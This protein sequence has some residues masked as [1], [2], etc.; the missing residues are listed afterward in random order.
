MLRKLTTYALSR[1]LANSRPGYR[2]KPVR[3]YFHLSPSGDFLGLQ[4]VPQTSEAGGHDGKILCPDIGMTAETR[5]CSVPIETASV[6]L[7]LIKKDE[8]C[9]RFY[10]Q[11]LEEGQ[12]IEPMLG[13]CLKAL[14]NKEVLQQ[15]REAFKQAD[16]LRKDLFGFRVGGEAVEQSPL[17]HRWW[18]GFY[19][20]ETRFSS[21]TLQRCLITGELTSAPLN[22]SRVRLKWPEDE[23][24]S[25]F[26][27][28]NYDSDVYSSFGFKQ[29]QNS[30]MNGRQIEMV[31][32]A[33]S[34][35]MERAPLLAGSRLLHWHE[36]PQPTAF[37]FHDILDGQMPAGDPLPDS[38]RFYLLF[39][40]SAEGHARVR[41]FLQ[42]DEQEIAKHL[43]RWAA[44]V[45]LLSPTG[46]GMLSCPPLSVLFARLIPPPGGKGS[47]SMD[48]ELAGLSPRLWESIL[49]GRPLPEEAPAR[50]L[51]YIAGYKSPGPRPLPDPY[52]CMWLKVWLLRRT[53][54]SAIQYAKLNRLS[55][56]YQAGRLLALAVSFLP[57]IREARRFLR[58]CR[59]YPGQMIAKMPSFCRER[60]ADLSKEERENREGILDEILTLLDGRFPPLSLEEE[61]R[62][63]LGFYRQS[64]VLLRCSIRISEGGR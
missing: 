2:L 52:A 5:K 30:S 62:T 49:L 57:D 32:E 58:L 53:P 18:D 35:L 37:S 3:A 27:L 6:I 36:K 59:L 40:S 15:M 16:Y 13:V 45:R 33:L 12:A 26:I 44:D 51:A 56:G 64:M 42:G 46:A 8:A 9:H 22:Y 39:L 63:V 24:L 10:L 21:R 55:A 1:Q 20:R 11:A 28:F 48:R 25:P 4:P 23:V 54:E 14:E 29:A 17:F 61:A 50:A 41:A 31:G 19:E 60:I 7:N 38:N 47:P 34:A 43:H